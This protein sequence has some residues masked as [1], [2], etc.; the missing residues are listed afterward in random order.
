MIHSLSMRSPTGNG[1]PHK[2]VLWLGNR[3]LV[4]GQYLNRVKPKTPE[5]K[6]GVKVNTETGFPETAV[7]S[8]IIAATTSPIGHL[9]EVAG[10]GQ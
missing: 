9:G 1:L 3:I 5:F 10:S 7:F 4:A 2:G 8:S 6:R